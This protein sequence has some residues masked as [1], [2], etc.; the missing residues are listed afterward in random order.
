[1]RTGAVEP[2]IIGLAILAEEDDTEYDVWREKLGP[3]DERN[4]QDERSEKDRDQRWAGV[5]DTIS[6]HGKLSTKEM[7]RER[8]GSPGA[9]GR[10]GTP[11]S[12]TLSTRERRP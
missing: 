6:I 9:A 1:M 2:L 12:R 11:G 5:A 3:V 8:T 10:P 4:V 7:A